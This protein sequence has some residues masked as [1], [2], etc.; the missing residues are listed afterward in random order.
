MGKKVVFNESQLEELKQ[1]MNDGI[2]QTDIAKHFK[3][4]DDTIRRICR[5][6]K[7][8]I[9]MPHKC[10]CIICG[11]VFYSNIKGAKTC[12]KEHHRTCTICG[13]DFIVD[14]T[15]IRDT[16]PG[17][18]TC[19]SK[20]GVDHASKV[21]QTTEK[22]I[23]TTREKYGVDNVSQLADHQE[24]SKMTCLEKYGSISYAGSEEGRSRIRATNLEKY[25]LEEPLGDPEYRDKL[26]AINKEKYGTEHP[27]QTEEVKAKIRQTNI[28]RYG[29]AN[30]MG[31]PEIQKKWK[32]N[33][34]KKH[35]YS[36]LMQDPEIKQNLSQT[37][38]E[39][40]GVPWSCMRPE[41]R[42]YAARSKVNR[43]FEQKL[44]ENNIEY[45]CEFVLNKY[46]FDF[47]CEN[48]L[49]EIN[50]T[51]THN[52]AISI[53]PGLDPLDSHYHLN[54]TNT[55]IENGYRCIN[56][57]DWDSW[58]AIIDLLKSKE[59]I[60]A[61]SCKLQE[62]PND[63]ASRFINKHHIQGQCKGATTCLGLLYKDELVEVMT[64]GKPRYNRNYDIELLRLCSRNDVKIIG[65]ASKLFKHYIKSNPGKSILSYCD[66]SKFSGAVYTA[67]G[68]TLEYQSDPAKIW[69][70]KTDYITD[71]LLR[72]R[73]YDQLFNT[74]YGKGTSNEEL[75][76]ENGWLPI[77]D[78][79]QKVF[80]YK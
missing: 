42:N 68:M 54:K 72:Q 1:M 63:E 79:G 48:V 64:F 13:K 38:Q 65:G 51:A 8:Q 34:R 25:G 28:N 15:D 44:V 50:P 37:C 6:N 10:K 59:V 61:R 18:C 31:N 75:M 3:V 21:Q 45:V 22:R 69:S 74:N 60:Y 4:T 24:K 56:I 53:F 77:Y 12:K 57:F 43:A 73:G 78:C 47:K 39:Q 52:S 66:A 33:F 32:Q 20:Y 62:I 2:R 30:V 9:R 26:F 14:R 16:C 55:A 71:N 80:S 7:I 36:H 46:S 29:T 19:L 17:K 35:G 76:L 41:A 58:D 5:E 49:I 40:Y 23:S 70:K 67:I 11:D 27:T